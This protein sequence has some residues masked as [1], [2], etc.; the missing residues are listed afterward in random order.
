MVMLTAQE[1]KDVE[2]YDRMTTAQMQEHQMPEDIDPVALHYA[3]MI[4]G[5]MDEITFQTEEIGALSRIKTAFRKERRIIQFCDYFIRISDA[6]MEDATD[7]VEKI[8]AE[9][10]S[11]RV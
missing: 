9:K 3:L 10:K 8:R 2:R 5:H 4:K 7:A 1:W 6:M 11:C